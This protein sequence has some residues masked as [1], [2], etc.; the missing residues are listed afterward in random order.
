MDYSQL[1][2]L[3]M[4]WLNAC[5]YI[6]AAD[7][8]M[9]LHVQ[10]PLIDSTALKAHAHSEVFLKLENCQPSGSFKLRGIGH[11]CSEVR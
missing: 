6:F 11:L 3:K 9:A 7:E 5:F 2:I 1:L 8:T 4:M 10:T